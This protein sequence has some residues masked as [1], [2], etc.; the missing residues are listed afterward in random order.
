M[1]KASVILGLMLITTGSRGPMLGAAISILIYLAF[2][3]RK[4]LFAFGIISAVTIFAATFI[5]TQQATYF[6]QRITSITDTQN[7]ASNYIRLALW[8]TGIAQIQ[9]QLTSGDKRFWLGNG[10]RGHE[11]ESTKFYENFSERATVQPGILSEQINKD[12]NYI[13][14]FHNMYIQSIVVAGA[15]WTIS[16][17]TIL[18]CIT[19]PHQSYNK[20]IKIIGGLNPALIN[21]LLIGVT[22][23][24]LPH[25][26]FLMIIYFLTLSA[27]NN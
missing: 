9:N 11:E 5:F 23:A 20:T 21:Y 25:F 19:I 12:T 18:I 15:I 27:N 8:E 7:D 24:I 4:A 10:Q 2:N 6:Q 22:Y 17:I 13:R 26:A 16:A 14:D 1:I 3:H